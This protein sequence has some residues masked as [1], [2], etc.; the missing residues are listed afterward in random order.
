MKLLVAFNPVEESVPPDG[1]Y[2]YFKQ[3]AS[4]LSRKGVQPYL[5]KDEGG[6][7]ALAREYTTE[8]ESSLKQPMTLD[9][10]DSTD[11]EV[12]YWPGEKHTRC[13]HCGKLTY[14][15]WGKQQ[16]HRCRYEA[17]DGLN[18][19]KNHTLTPQLDRYKEK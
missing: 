12:Y 4:H 16:H 7:F 1:V 8:L 17:C 15:I 6:R 5:V 13:G 2:A 11:A 9:I 14:F 19:L 3:W 18:D 10:I